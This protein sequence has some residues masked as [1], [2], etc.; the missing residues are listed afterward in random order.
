MVEMTQ[1]QSK[2]W[3]GIAYMILGLWTISALDCLS[4]SLMESGFHI[5]AIMWM[6]YMINLF[7]VLVTAVP[8]Y[9]KA[10]GKKAY[11]TQ[12]PIYQV[13]RGI[14][15][16]LSVFLFYSMLNIMPVAEATTMNFCSPLL[17]L[18][19]S[20]LMLKEK[21][22]KARW[23]AVLTG[24]AGMLIVIRPGGDIPPM[25][26]VY[27]LMSAT[28]YAFF[29]VLGRKLGTKDDPM[30][31]LFYGVLTGTVICSVTVPFF[32]L[33]HLPS[34]NHVIALCSTGVVST[35]GH[36]L[37]NTAYKNAEASI[38]MP[39]TY[40]QI[41]SATF[42]GWLCFGDFPDSMTLVGIAVICASGVG[43]AVY[44]YKKSTSGTDIQNAEAR[45]REL[46]ETTC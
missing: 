41:I 2:N 3:I 40:V 16:F 25:G 28:A 34:F 14:F 5:I 24:F 15:F 18:A 9:Q 1:E 19:L 32:W 4:K 22:S 39:F 45:D 43:I 17:V 29:S 27:G 46:D 13:L 31:T 35:V 12:L 6:R 37:V 7:F 33:T 36:L 42:F 20:P 11:K 44:E 21:S 26:V 38:L 30:V 8:W 23:L 10:T